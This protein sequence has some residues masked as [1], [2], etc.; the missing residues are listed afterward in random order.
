[1]MVLD[2]VG[3]QEA[4]VYAQ[5]VQ[6][7][8]VRTT[9][10]SPELNPGTL[11]CLSARPPDLANAAG[12]RPRVVSMFLSTVPFLYSKR[13]A[14]ARSPGSRY[15]RLNVLWPLRVNHSWIPT[16]YLQLGTYVIVKEPRQP[17]A[18]MHP[19]ECLL[20]YANTGSKLQVRSHRDT[21]PLPS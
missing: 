10:T 9:E 21:T 13:T 12:T 16:L 4:M 5:L 17:D 2:H 3:D 1:M 20:P 7:P 15:G 11:S 14:A 6:Q 19:S 18:W 8:L